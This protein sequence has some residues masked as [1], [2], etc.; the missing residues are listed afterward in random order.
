VVRTRVSH[1]RVRRL[2]VAVPSDV[3]GAQGEGVDVT[4]LVDG[5]GGG[6]QGWSPPK[7]LMI[8]LGAAW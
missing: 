6:G 8:R 5:C 2:G 3:R 1:S 7:R 4:Y